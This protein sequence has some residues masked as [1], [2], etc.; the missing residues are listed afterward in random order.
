M[1]L[2]SEAHLA[3]LKPVREEAAEEA[4]AKR[5]DLE[6]FRGRVPQVT[7]WVDALAENSCNIS[8]RKQ[9]KVARR[10]DTDGRAHNCERRVRQKQVAI[11]AEWVRNGTRKRL[12]E[13]SYV[14]LALDEAKRRR[15]VR[16][17]CDT[18]RPPY[19]ATGVLGIV[20]GAYSSLDELTD[21]HVI[22]GARHLED[23]F[24][25]FFTPR[26]GTLD[27]ELWGHFKVCVVTLSADGAASERR[28]LFH[29]MR[30]IFPN[31][32]FVVRDV[33]HQLRISCSKRLHA[34]GIFENIWTELFDKRHA[35]VPDIQNS[36]KWKDML[37]AIQ[38]ECLRIEDR[39]K[40]METVLRHLS[41]AKQRFES[42]ADP[43]AK[44]VLMLLPVATL[45]AYIS[46]D[47][48]NTSEQRLRATTVL[49]LLTPKYCTAMGVSAD[50]AFVSKAFLRKYDCSN[51]DAS[52]SVSE[53]EKFERDMTAAFIE[54]KC[55]EP[56]LATDD[57]RW[58]TDIARGQIRRKVV[59]RTGEEQ[60]MLWGRC[61]E[62]DEQ[63][64]RQRIRLVT[65]NALE[66]TR[67]ELYASPM[68][69]ALQCF[70]LDRV[71]AGFP[72]GDAS[73][74]NREVGTKKRRACLAGVADLAR[75]L[76]LDPAA[77]ALE[78]R[79]AA[80]Y[81]VQ[82]H[83]G[84]VAAREAA[85]GKSDEPDHRQ[86]WGDILRKDPAEISPGRLAPF[87]TLSKLIRYNLSVE[88][89]ECQ[90]E[91]DL[92]VLTAAAGEHT[93][94]ADR[95][96]L[97]LVVVQQSDLTNKE[98]CSIIWSMGSLVRLQPPFGAAPL[99]HGV[100]WH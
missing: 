57:G 45:L 83:T 65:E 21:D 67:T 72:S 19:T 63:E 61:R 13:A 3:A 4:E 64:I 69:I 79:D 43:L 85:G 31:V 71:R 8:F 42:K 98:F 5:L 59:F 100:R 81:V 62:A 77:A 52:R 32:C 14:T 10:K 15:L 70:D 47:S 88:D 7:D 9:E 36:G 55:F 24:K 58:L 26:G 82:A 49:K 66:R 92:G 80:A 54:G 25:Q 12:R 95:T 84:R 90:V 35:L 68:R 94:A 28:L 16:F 50:Y 99:G 34:D 74:A 53:L 39:E 48:R 78:Y 89:G 18:P 33:A 29:L 76:K 1:Y 56:P 91:R 60:L 11:M 40:P 96:L 51:H 30:V 86:T 41:F 37:S 38:I 44:L 27:L 6:I 93:G 46:S 20:N 87:R 23:F 73:D 97:D 17:R 22:N 2:T 75:F